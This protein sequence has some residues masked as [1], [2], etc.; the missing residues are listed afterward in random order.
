LILSYFP[1]TPIHIFLDLEG[2]EGDGNDLHSLRRSLTRKN[3]GKT[4]V[5]LWKDREIGL[6]ALLSRSS[7]AA[8]VPELAGKAKEL[9]AE[10]FR[11]RLS[12]VEEIKTRWQ[13]AARKLREQSTPVSL[14]EA[15]TLEALVAAA[16]DWRVTEEAVGFLAVNHNL[17][18]YA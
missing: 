10:R 18:R 15:D 2:Q 6:D 14:A 3:K 8:T 4:W 16:S 1:S 7:W 12:S 9:A 13:T 11:Q 5:N 17:V